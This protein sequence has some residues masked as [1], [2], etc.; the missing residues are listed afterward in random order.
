MLT[1]EQLRRLLAEVSA[2]ERCRE[3][4]RIN[5]LAATGLRESELLVSTARSAVD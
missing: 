2:S 4:D 5:V 1:A 3:I